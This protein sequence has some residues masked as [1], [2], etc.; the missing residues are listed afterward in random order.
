MRARGLLAALSVLACV[1]TVLNDPRALNPRRDWSHGRTRQVALLSYSFAGSTEGWGLEAAGPGSA[2]APDVAHLR[3]E[4]RA[5]VAS[6]TGP[7]IWYFHTPEEWSGDRSEVYNGEMFLK[8]WHPEQPSAGTD[9]AK[10]VRTKKSADVIIETTCGF[11]VQLYDFFPPPR[12]ASSVYSIPISE[13]AASWIDSRTQKRVTQVDLLVALS[14]LRVIKFRG[15]SLRGAETVR[16]AEFR[17]VPPAAGM[18]VRSDLE[19][20]CSPV[21][22]FMDPPHPIVLIWLAMA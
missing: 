15:G 3:A 21:S 5:L 20:C 11:S 4:N 13:E 14:H 2:P 10:S 7:S 1:G 19:P 12:V 9:A 22:S 16:L 18:P 8:L 6:D 17:I